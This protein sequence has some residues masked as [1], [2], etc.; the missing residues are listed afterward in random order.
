MPLILSGN[1]ASATAAAYDVAN[2]CRFN[3]GDSP[4]M[5]KSLGTPTSTKIGTFSCWVKLG[6]ITT[7]QSMLGAYA[8]SSNRHHLEFQADHN[9]EFFGKASNSTNMSLIT[10]AYYRDPSA[11][12]NVVVAWD[13]SQGTD[14]N[15]VK[16]YVNGTQVTS[17][18]TETYPDQNTVLQ[19]NTDG[20]TIAIGRNQGGN[21][22]D[23]YLAEVVFIDG[24][25]YAA[26]DF[27]EFNSDSPTIWQ[28]KDVSGLT[29]G[30]EGFYCDM[31]A[32]DNLGNDANGGTDLTEA[33][34]AATDQAQDSPTNNWC[35]LNSLLP[36]NN[37][38]LSEG[39]VYAATTTASWS[40]ESST[41]ALTA[42][43]WYFEVKVVG[44][45]HNV[46]GIQNAD[47]ASA[48][49]GG[50]P[51]EIAGAYGFKCYDGSKTSLAADSASYGDAVSNDEIVGC[52]I[53]LDNDK[54]YWSINNTWQDS[55]DP[56]SGATGTGSAFDLA[57]GITYVVC[58]AL[59]HQTGNAL[60][61]F[62]FGCPSHSN[63]SDAA[64]ANGY[65]AFEY[66]PPSGY[67]SLCTKNLGSDGG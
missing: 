65:G 9:I 39:N 37:I 25:A 26:S 16:L 31:E 38:T 3:D 51:F 48:R 14:S 15:R 45:N 46:I 2:S 7:E 41:F 64:D 63:S 43:K 12:Y 19:F 59:N 27:G 28:P 1:V 57:T 61:S 54:I 53:D 35:V 44:Y 18:A 47:N 20:S 33:N 29:F 60:S 10:N 8:D 4:S 5:T 21:Y 62:N 55:G 36:A 23:G 42:G 34:L 40:S 66:A 52:A 67:L 6:N 30:D 56:T 50:Y 24:T 17:F 58:N 11:W 49:A 32:S 13:T 22:A